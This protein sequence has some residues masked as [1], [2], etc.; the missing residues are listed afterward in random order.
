MNTRN[1]FAKSFVDANTPPLPGNRLLKDRRGETYGPHKVYAFY[2]YIGKA[3]AWWCFNPKHPKKFY[4]LKSTALSTFTWIKKVNEELAKQQAPAQPEVVAPQE[5]L[6]GEHP[7]KTLAQLV[8]SFFKDNNIPVTQEV[9]LE[10]T[11]KVIKA[12]FEREDFKSAIDQIRVI[13]EREFS[14]EIKKEAL[15]SLFNKKSA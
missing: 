14:D 3:V 7:S 15:I 13:M 4:V 9:Y 10:T 11:D 6:A 12:C 5:S 1:F 2:G 8:M